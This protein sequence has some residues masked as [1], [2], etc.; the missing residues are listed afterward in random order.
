MR[1]DVLSNLISD[2]RLDPMEMA[3]IEKLINRC[4]ELEIENAELRS[5]AAN[6]KKSI[7]E[8]LDVLASTAA[9]QFTARVETTGE[10]EIV[11]ALACGVNMLNEEL[12]DSTVSYEFVN[13]VFD[14][15]KDMLFVV[16]SSNRIIKVN[17]AVALA[18][19][20]DEQ[21]FIG[22]RID[23]VLKMEVESEL[24]E[25]S[26][27]PQMVSKVI[28]NR[29][30]G[31]YIPGAQTISKLDSNGNGNDGYIRVVQDLTTILS[32]EKTSLRNERR[33]K[34]LL[35][36]SSVG[37][38][39][40]YRNNKIV[41]TNSALQKMLGYSVNELNNL[42]MAALIDSVL[43]SSGSM[44]QL[45]QGVISNLFCEQVYKTKAGQKLWTHTNIVFVPGVTTSEKDVFL[46]TIMDTSELRKVANELQ[47]KNEEL[48]DKNE[49]LDSFAYKA[50]HELK[51][52]AIN[53][54]SMVQMLMEQIKHDENPLVHQVLLKLKESSIRLKNTIDDF[55]SIAS[56]EQKDVM[57]QEEIV[58][59]D[60]INE[61]IDSMREEL[62][63]NDAS[64][65]VN[66][67]NNTIFFSKVNFRSIILNLIS[68]ALKYSHPDR[69]PVI[70]VKSSVVDGRV[71]LQVTDNGTGINLEKN[72]SK[73][74][75]MFS[76]LDNASGIEGTGIGLYIIKKMIEK[77]NGHILVES[78]FGLWTRFTIVFNQNE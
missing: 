77:E 54:L 48:T 29:R 4:S 40:T 13:K 3:A 22:L 61:I 49:A 63:S 15:M 57:D 69:E 30:G 43:H 8:V 20:F 24:E 14:S 39:L 10:D 64:I 73:M 74:F 60:E 36:S 55:L 42:N 66:T 33:F 5:K 51:T 72:A 59:D 16:D 67:N 45:R 62:G 26:Q 56:A 46:F 38:A 58:L 34:A 27:N 19:G 9:S 52:P 12:K 41:L 7:S 68:N 21:E 25:V 18:T 75:S 11:N 70:D 78:E 2:S 17:K 50:S 65:N 28:L 32:L 6:Q 44:D 76:R 71:N 23:L 35:H 1:G 47:V 53:V 37:V 31:G